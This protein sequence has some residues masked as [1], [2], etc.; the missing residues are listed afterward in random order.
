[1]KLLSPQ[2]LLMK[3]IFWSEVSHILTVIGGILIIT[4]CILLSKKKKIDKAVNTNFVM[5]NTIQ[6]VHKVKK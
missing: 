1:M 6:S 5:G 4:A 3:V 2:H